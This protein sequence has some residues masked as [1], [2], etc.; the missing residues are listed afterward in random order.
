MAIPGQLMFA[1]RL[2]P[3]A[4]LLI[5]LGVGIACVSLDTRYQAME[6]LRSGLAAVLQP[7]REVLRT[8]GVLFAEIGGFLTQHRQLQQERDA[9]LRERMQLRSEAVSARALSSENT[10]LRRL[11]QLPVRS[12][13][14]TVR[15]ALLY[16]GQDWFAQRITLDQGSE[17][18]LRAGQPVL[19]A[20]GLVGQIGR[21]YA[22]SSEVWLVSNTDQLTPVMVERTGQRGLASGSGQTNLLDL[23]YLPAQTD[24]RPGD[25]LL[26]SGIDRVY[27]PGIPVGRVTRVTRP[28]ASPYL[29][30]DALPLAGI[31][32]ARTVLVLVGS[33][34]V[35][36][37]PAQA[38][39]P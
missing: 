27:P 20:D 23:R 11:M 32:H 38:V 26:T 37:L 4:R 31:A 19:D 17:A 10:E 9:L 33:P 22:Q 39:T 35:A 21:V 14:Q 2:G 18:G 12:S 30:V 1:R 36:P 28:Q 13:T 29:R 8:P 15:A 25:R 34:Q 24:I 6:G 7:V 3:T 5:W 16:Q